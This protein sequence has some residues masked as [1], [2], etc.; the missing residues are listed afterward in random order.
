MYKILKSMKPTVLGKKY[1]SP[2]KQ[3]VK[4]KLKSGSECTKFNLA[5]SSGFTAVSHC[6]SFHFLTLRSLSML[7]PCHT[8]TC[9]ESDPSSKCKQ[10]VFLSLRIVSVQQH[11]WTWVYLRD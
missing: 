6:D 10:K 3:L 7:I 2:D 5:P 1:I 8:P 4:S 11:V 9:T